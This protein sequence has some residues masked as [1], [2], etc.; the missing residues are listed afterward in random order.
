MC[1]G[2]LSRCGRRHVAAF[3]ILAALRIAERTGVGQFIDMSMLDATMSFLS[4]HGQ[5]ISRRV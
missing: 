4:I 5:H 2:C 1:P 3:A